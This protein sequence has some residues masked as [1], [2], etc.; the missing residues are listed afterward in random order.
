[1]T[2]VFWMRLFLFWVDKDSKNQSDPNVDT[3]EFLPFNSKT[4][5]DTIKIETFCTW[6]LKIFELNIPFFE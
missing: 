6:V 1:M 3:C 4:M 2:L 5:S